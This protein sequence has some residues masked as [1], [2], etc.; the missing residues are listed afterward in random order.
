MTVPTPNELARL[1]ADCL[2]VATR[3]AA[4]ARAGFGGRVANEEKSPHDIVTEYDVRTE[5]EILAIL[6]RRHPGVPVVAEEMGE[7]PDTSSMELAFCVDPI[8]GTTNFSIGHPF[9]CVSIG[10]LARGVPVAG[11]VIAPSIATTWHGFVGE[12]GGVFKNGERRSVSSTTDLGH[13]VLGTG[14]PPVRD[15]APDNNFDSFMSVKKRVRAVRR[16]GAA[17]IDMCF[18]ADGTYDGYWERRL[19]LWDCAAGAAFIVAGGGTITAL[20][21]G[22]P[23]FARG[24]I[25][26]T[27]GKIHDQLV[28]AVNGLDP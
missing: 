24:H 26:A 6:Q 21:G 28:R 19:L 1:T 15:V 5:Q 13:C 20:D 16:C 8:D 12:G 22:P 27:N 10:V 14:F 11:A 7:A 23:I 17:A 25:V 4:V 9:W 3:G 18:V 2:E